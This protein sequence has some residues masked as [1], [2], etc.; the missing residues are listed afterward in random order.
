M[1]TYSLYLSTLS[2]I[3]VPTNK[4]N[5]AQVKWSVNWREIFGS[6][7][8][9]CRVRTHIISKSSNSITWANNVGSCR[10]NLASNTSNCSA[11]LNLGMVR[12]M[13]DFTTG[14]TTTTTTTTI[15]SST[16]SI[17][18]VTTT[19]TLNGSNYLQSSVTTPSTVTAAATSSTST[20]STSTVGTTYL[21]CDTTMSSGLSMNIPS[22]N[23]EV[24]VT[25][26]SSNDSVL[27]TNVQDYQMWL[28]F[29]VDSED[30]YVLSN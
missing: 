4:S 28:Y 16:S 20:A 7:V 29:D 30:P 2:A 14:S 1:R 22:F 27:M 25:F 6:K 23:S 21:E 3:N 18:A 15:P 11:G 8:G 17:P 5:L 13:N 10:I 24:V 12:P 26:L 9:N 19:Y